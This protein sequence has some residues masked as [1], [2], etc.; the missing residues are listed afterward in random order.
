[1]VRD[2][3]SMRPGGLAADWRDDADDS[4]DTWLRG[5]YGDLKD[6]A[7]P[8]VLPNPPRTCPCGIQ[9]IIGTPAD[10]EHEKSCGHP[11]KPAG[12]AGRAEISN[13][14]QQ[15]MALSAENRDLRRRLA[16]AE[17]KLAAGD[18]GEPG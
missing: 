7:Y 18:D 15:I 13:P 4:P 3:E 10:R 11:A 16:A 14:Q 9:V 12:G 17:A 1:M 6:G 8:S 2:V 5:M